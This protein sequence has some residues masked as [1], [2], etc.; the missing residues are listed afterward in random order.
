M[1][2]GSIA[3]TQGAVN[4]SSDS[5]SCTAVTSS[6]PSRRLDHR[7]RVERRILQPLPHRRR[8]PRIRPRRRPHAPQRPRQRSPAAAARSRRR[9]R[10]RADPQRQRLVAPSSRRRV[11]ED[12]RPVPRVGARHQ[13]HCREIPLQRPRRPRCCPDSPAPTSAAPAGS[14]ATSTRQTG[15]IGDQRCRPASSSVNTAGQRARACTRTV[16]AQPGRAG[17]PSPRRCRS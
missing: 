3:C 13:S 5:A 7:A 15:A 17:A 8:R 16:P 9:R 6:P 2:N 12:R 10:P 4:R 11:V 14:I 1:R